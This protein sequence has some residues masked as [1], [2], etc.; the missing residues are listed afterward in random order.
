M[1]FIEWDLIQVDPSIDRKREE[2][3]Y[4]NYF[5]YTRIRTRGGERLRHAAGRALA[6]FGHMLVRFGARLETPGGYVHG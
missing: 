4:R 2:R 1:G 5:I 6:G 3:L